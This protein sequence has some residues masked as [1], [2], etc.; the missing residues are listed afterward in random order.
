MGF[1]RNQLFECITEMKAW[2][3][4]NFLHLND[5][6]TEVMLFKPIDAFKNTGWYGS[7]ERYVT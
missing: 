5:E 2:L 6:T 3:S 1:L 7:S 4:S